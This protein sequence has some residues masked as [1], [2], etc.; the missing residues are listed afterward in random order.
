MICLGP[1]YGLLYPWPPTTGRPHATGTPLAFLSGVEVPWSPAVCQRLLLPLLWAILLGFASV[2]P[3][4]TAEH[5]TRARSRKEERVRHHWWV[6]EGSPKNNWG[7]KTL[8][9]FSG[10]PNEESTNDILTISET[11]KPCSV[12]KRYKWKEFLNVLLWQPKTF[13]YLMPSKTSLYLQEE[14]QRN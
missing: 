7:D 12:L 5:P 6:G 13:R 1:L 11:K 4:R 10:P 14:V 3:R 8:L 2:L 9:K